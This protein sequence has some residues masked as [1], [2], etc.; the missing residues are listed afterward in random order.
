L[1][2]DTYGQTLLVAALVADFITILLVSVYATLQ[3]GATID[4]LLILVLLV[5]FAVAYRLAERARSNPPA[6][7]L[8]H[9]LSTATSQI[10]VRGSLALALV[11]MA[12]AESLGIENILGAFLAGVIVSLLSGSESSVLREKLDAI[13]YG[14]FIPIFFIMVGVKFDLPALLAWHAPWKTVGVLIVAAFGVKLMGTLVFRLAFGWRETW[15]ASALL[16]ARLSFIVAVS[17]IGVELGVISPALN[18][19]IILVAIVSCLTAP[20]AFARLV[21]RRY[22]AAPRILVIGGDRDGA[23]L[24]R[25]LESAGR[26]AHL[27][28][29]LPPGENNGPPSRARLSECLRSAGIKQAQTVIAL[30]DS[31]EENL[32]ICRVAHDVY[33]VRHLLA[34]VRDPARNPRFQAAGVRVVNPAYAKLLLLA[35]MALDTAQMGGGVHEDENH[36]IR[37]AK[38]HNSGLAGRQLRHL[39]LPQGARVLRLERH[40]V[41]LEAEPSTVLRVNDTLTVTGPREDIDGLARLLA[42]RW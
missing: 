30:A 24:A 36:E 7:R 28:A 12:L 18:A 20:I 31:D 2:A 4:L 42:R 5:A 39:I 19:A 16:S 14:F 25:R 17:A 27:V 21:P 6:Q 32:R 13:G 3:A 37:I 11:F 33:A 1:L 40:G 9:A 38:L 34:W 23:T 15:A 26:N 35:G 8:M 22:Q 29:D 41:I 10:Q